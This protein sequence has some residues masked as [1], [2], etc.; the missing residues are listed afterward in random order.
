MKN[1]LLCLSASAGS[2]KTYRLVMRYL[3]LLFLGAKPSSILTLTFTKKAAKEMEE[4]IIHQIQEIY[5][6]KND[7]EYIKKLEFITIN[8][9]KEIE[10]KIVQIY[11]NFLKED[12][13]ITT[14]DAFFGR[15]LKNFCWYV[16]VKNNFKIASQ[17]DEE[18]ANLFL[19]L[20]ENTS[21]N[22][23]YFN[24]AIHFMYQ[25]TQDLES[26]LSLCAY[27]DS[28]L[29]SLT[30]SLFNP[31][32]DNQSLIELKEKA[33]I[34]GKKIQED[35]LTQKES[36]HSALEFDSFE[37][38]LNKG[39]TWLTKESLDKFRG[40]SK[41]SFDS[42]N[43]QNLKDCLVEIFTLEEKQYLQETYTFLNLYLKAKELYF[44]KQNFLSF[45]LVSKKV[46]E[47]LYKEKISQDF[48]YFRLD[49]TLSH[50]LIDEFQ[51]TSILQYEI[52]KPLIDEIKAGV[53]TKNFLRSFF[54]VGD[55]KQSIYR[56]RGGNPNLFE[57]ASSSMQKEYMDTN[58]RSAKNIV[59]FINAVFSQKI[60]GFIPQ[61][62]KSTLKGFV[63]ITQTQNLKESAFLIL[64]D[65]LKK[66]AKEEE[67][68]LLVF[69][70][71]AVVETATFLQEKDLKVVMDTSTKL[72]KHNEVRALIEYLHFCESNN[73]LFKEEFFM[74]LGLKTQELP[75]F[76]K[77][78]EPSIKLLKIMEQYKIA[79]L[80]AKK[81]LE[82]SLNFTNIKELL[83][84][85]ERLEADIVSSDF[86]G[87]RIMTIHKSKG[88][89]FENIILLDR[90]TK[91]TNKR[92]KLFFE[93]KDNGIEI[94]RIYKLS[95]P[96]REHLDT[97]YK[98]AIEKEKNLIDRE[99]K[100]QLYVG[101]TRAKN[102]MHILKNEEK[103]IFDT[104]AIQT[105][106]IGDLQEAILEYQQKSFSSPA[107]C[108]P[109]KKEEFTKIFSQDL[110]RQTKM[111]I[112]EKPKPKGNLESLYYGI[113]FH[114]AMEQKLK[115]KLEDTILK[116]I[117]L[118]KMGFYLK[119]ES[120][121]NIINK[122]NISLNYP[123][124]K[125]ILAKGSVKCEV[126][127]LI[128]G[129]QKRLDILIEN[130]KEA[131]VVDYKSGSKSPAYQ[132]QMKE[133]IKCV[134]KF[135]NK[136]VYG[137]LFY[138]EGKGEWIEIMQGGN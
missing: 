67:I 40:F 114:Y 111:Q 98:T 18:I 96:L 47:L 97:H 54:Y 116:N 87:I 83:E 16:G 39:K 78:K 21:L 7:I 41:I 72:I 1:A 109:N 135:L 33:L 49:S 138:T 5:N 26:L 58:Y 15:I 93:F 100:N 133:Y 12:L 121:N 13:K 62:A 53:G 27:L 74:L 103:S 84:E 66:G 110:G 127:F 90:S 68:A 118:N 9:P 80:S 10:E 104:L 107:P 129:R 105:Q 19:E 48:L 91:P 117:L 112:I 102:T 6:H 85:V 132:E 20:L 50:I 123:K 63:N 94:K 92:G 60:T 32:C 76:L 130:A 119:E 56:F 2:G 137:Y 4:R 126:P 95:N 31:Q 3:E 24:K 43:F 59:D 79:S 65:L 42:Q 28:F 51:D 45:E 124:F 38:M 134:E 131:F 57:I 136:P 23:L 69:D 34:C 106:K 125:E 37:E 35:Y 113:A 44:Q 64:Q 128:E 115:C 46:Y 99:L 29:E 22:S 71:K 55:I 77:H 86:S 36:L 101:L 73:P 82:Y 8:N 120:I 52:L 108:H 75:L 122:C 17:N 89:E 25:N 81:F 70:N 88:L 61:I 11:H 14:I 30:P